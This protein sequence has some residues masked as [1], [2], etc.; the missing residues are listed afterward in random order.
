V[1]LGERIEALRRIRHTENFPPLAAAFKRIRNILEKSAAAETIPESPDP[2]KFTAEEERALHS[3]AEAAV[4]DVARLKQ[5]RNYQPA[6]ERIAALRP[7]V[8]RFF[9]KV[10]VMAED[11]A[12]RSNRL[13][14]LRNLLLEF[15]IIADFSEIVTA[16][17]APRKS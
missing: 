2:A 1:D 8:D 9:D 5:A 10:M 3:A 13:A 6:L 4:A 12:V 16:V 15:S 17:T 11:R 14:L 7:V